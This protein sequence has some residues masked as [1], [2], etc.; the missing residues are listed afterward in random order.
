MVAGRPGL[1]KFDAEAEG[2]FRQEC[3]DETRKPLQAALLLGALGF[4][5]FILLDAAALGLSL[6]AILA[7]SVVVF[8]LLGLY[9][10]SRRA[11]ARQDSGRIAAAAVILAVLDLAVTLLLE[12]DP[13][14]YA[15]A[16]PGLLPVYFFLYGQLLLPLAFSLLIGWT[17]MAALLWTGAY[18]GVDGAGLLP[19]FLILA[20]VNLFGLCTRR[21]LER[22]SRRAF[23]QRHAAECAAEDKAAFLRQTSHNLRQPLQALGC[24]A[25]ALEA[26]LADGKTDP[27]APVVAKLGAVV[28]E[29]Q[30]ACNRILDMAALQTG[31]MAVNLADVELNPLL[32]ALQDQFAPK[33]AQRGLTL[34]VLP[35]NRP[36]FRVRSDAAMLRQVLGNL[37]DNAIKYTPQGCVVLATQ[38]VGNT[39]LELQVR[40]SGLGIAAEERE[41]V[42]REFYR[43]PRQEQACVHGLGIG[44]AYVAQALRCLPQH[45]LDL[46]SRPGHGSVFSLVLPNG[47]ETKN[48]PSSATQFSVAGSYVLLAYGDAAV[49]GVLAERLTRWGCLVEPVADLVQ[50]RRALADNLRPPD[51]LLADYHWNRQE[52]AADALAAAQADSGPVPA[53]VFSADV[54]LPLDANR[55]SGSIQFLDKS[56]GEKALLAA[57]AK[58]LDASLT[59]KSRD[60]S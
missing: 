14:G 44:L 52:T 8:G 57:M 2:R 55:W 41:A 48:R 51:L 29:L 19:S 25:T 11:A 7:R 22:Y 10:R 28:D 60:V 3:I 13:A 4:F 32:A 45:Q 15:T 20:I 39:R 54:A 12:N 27:L 46:A 6:A 38:R 56:A 43:S 17:G 42:F 50:L 49:R 58:A 16:W 24:Y 36:P 5:L 31:G 26:A 40:D 30:E 23:R 53:V 9:L 47:E 34:K 21:Q 37:L 18:V 59:A 33:A 1:A 35:R